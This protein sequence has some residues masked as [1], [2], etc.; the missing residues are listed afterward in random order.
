MEIKVVSQKSKKPIGTFT[1]GDKA[2]LLDLK[3]QVKS[4]TKRSIDRIRLSIPKSGSSNLF[5]GLTNNKDLVSKFVGNDGTIYYKDLGPQ[6]SW[7]LVFVCEYAGPLF[8]YPLFYFLP[9]IFYG[10]YANTEKTQVQNIA[11]ICYSL[12]YIKRVLETLF[13]HR[14][15]NGTMPIFNL[16]K[17]CSYYWGCTA[18]VS[19]FVNHPLFTPPPMERVYIGLGLFIFG[20][21]SN[22]IC[23][24]MLRNLRPAGSTERKI[25]RGFL[26]ELVSCP[27][28]TVEI[29]SWIGFSI[30]TQTLTSYIFTLMGAAQMWV[31]AVGKHKRYRREFG[32][33]YPRSRKILIP[34]LL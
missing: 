18:M 4:K 25:P 32:D 30:L 3:N 17:N 22:L 12:H 8:V 6:I 31:W 29:L 28:Y 33:K 24:I 34:F 27:N 13:V 20:E 19:Y 11:L 9:S 5:E 7:T 26:F 10:S 16:F 2:T 1:V 14:F 21:I 23:H 15:S